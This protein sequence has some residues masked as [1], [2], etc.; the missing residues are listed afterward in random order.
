MKSFSSS[1]LKYILMVFLCVMIWG[2]AYP[3]VRWLSL[4][5][6]NAYLIVCMRVLFSCLFSCLL[7]LFTRTKLDPVQI[8]HN[9]LPFALLGVC[10]SAGF[11]TLMTLGL[12]FTEAG[13]GSFLVGV[14]PIYIVL[15]SA[16]FLGESLTARKLI[17]VVVAIVGVCFTLVGKEILAGA[18]LTFSSSDLILILAGFLWATYTLLSRKLGHRLDYFQ[19]LFLMF[20]IS[21]LL[22]LPLFIHLW[23]E[24]TKLSGK[25]LFWALWCGFMP[26]GFGYLL[27]NKGV[28]VLGASTCGMINSFLAVFSTIYSVIFLHEHMVWLQILGGVLVVVGVLQGISHSSMPVNYET[29][30]SVDDE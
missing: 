17:G 8:R 22:I 28:N 12:Q 5:G 11:L 10:G 2:S 7:L 23:P 19:G 26:G 13:K 1:R 16:I 20:G 9:L 14:N 4:S 29:G 6:V 30:R 3:A 15:L 21:S 25:Q 18:R 27:W 24:F